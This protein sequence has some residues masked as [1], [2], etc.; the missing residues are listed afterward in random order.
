MTRLALLLLLMA[1]QLPSPPRVG[2]VPRAA[3]AVLAALGLPCD[4][5]ELAAVLDADGDGRVPSDSIACGIE[6]YCPAVTAWCNW[7]WEP[8]LYRRE[9]RILLTCSGD[10]TRHAVAI[11]DSIPAP[12]GA[13]G[14]VTVRK[15]TR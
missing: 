12:I 13:W 5:V 7:G 14:V 10:S 6:A 15:E 1:C 8:D 3:G 2:C 4:T 9:P 11:Y